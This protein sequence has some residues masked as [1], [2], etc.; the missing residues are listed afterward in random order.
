MLKIIKIHIGNTREMIKILQIAPRAVAGGFAGAA[1]VFCTDLCFVSGVV[2]HTFS[3][4]AASRVGS[5]F[6]IYKSTNQKE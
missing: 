2:E 3:A 5:V 1:R 4:H 6:P